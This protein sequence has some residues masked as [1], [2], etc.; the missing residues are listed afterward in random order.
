METSSQ[1]TFRAPDSFIG[2]TTEAARMSGL[3]RSEYARKA[4]EEAN[5]RAM[6]RRIASLSRRLAASTDAELDALDSTA[7]DGLTP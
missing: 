6:Q 4:I 2:E 1:F 3:S 5:G 7:A